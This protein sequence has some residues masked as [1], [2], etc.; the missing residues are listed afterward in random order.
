MK[1]EEAFN[2]LDKINLGASV[3]EA[4]LAKEYWPVMVGDLPQMTRPGEA[5]EAERN[6]ARRRRSARGRRS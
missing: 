1:K 6:G 5:R 3:A 4:L 2:P